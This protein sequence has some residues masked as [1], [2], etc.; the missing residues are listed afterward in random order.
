MRLSTCFLAWTTRHVN[1]PAVNDIRGIR[2]SVF[3]SG[4]VILIGVCASILSKVQPN[5]QFSILGLV[6][7][8]CCTSTLCM[9]FVPKL[10]SELEDLTRQLNEPSPLKNLIIRSSVSV[11]I[12]TTRCIPLHFS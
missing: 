7:I 5:V 1:I 12:L 11:V 2:F 6:I 8:T 10:D 3:V 4:P 9:V